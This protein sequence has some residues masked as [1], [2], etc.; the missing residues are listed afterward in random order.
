MN[1]RRAAI[2]FVLLLAGASLSGL[3]L[4]QHYGEGPAVTAVQ[5]IC[6][7][8]SQSGCETVARSAY[9]TVGSVPLA[10][11]GL[12]FYITLASLL[13]LALLAG[14]AAL[15]AGGR[16]VAFALLLALAFDIVL[17]GIQA[18]SIKAYCKVCLT[19]YAVNLV[20]L[21]VLL[22]ALR[23]TAALTALAS[24]E[25]RL[26]LAGWGLTSGAVAAALLAANLTLTYREARRT[27]GL[28]GEPNASAVG[29]GAEDE[30]RRL[31]EILDDPQKREQYVT[32]KA[33]KEF[34][35]AAPQT[36]DVSKAPMSGSA[37]AAIHVVEFSDYLCPFCRALAGA[38]K[39]YVPKSQGRVVVHYKNYP[40]EKTCNTKL[41][42]TIHEGAC[43]LALSA[44]C[45]QEQ[46]RFAQYQEAVFATPARPMGREDAVRIATGAGLAAP[47]LQTCL[48]APETKA[49][50]TAEI[51]EG[52]RVGVKGTPTVFVGGKR[53][54]RVND[55][56][57]AIEK[58]AGRLG[59][60]PLPSPPAAKP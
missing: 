2:V 35:D 48:D 23:G 17:F 26:V 54:P 9:S 55:F 30:V 59:L 38:F 37:N 29:R 52:E 60:P 12:F 51:E 43:W 42:N 16:L 46:G 32:D 18:F 34:E 22:P 50:L 11:V 8:G 24:A 36:L 7:E 19:T 27:A 28:L 44:I 39:D 40:L 4:L 15:A 41:Q 1:Q 53:L 33:L 10:A 20:A 47:A 25:G 14:P 6:G 58:E 45:A 57:A 5:A 13:A 31:K 21:L 49:R 56:L 3:L